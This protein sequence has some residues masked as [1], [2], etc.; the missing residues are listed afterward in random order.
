[1]I[2]EGK[3]KK[4]LLFCF[5][6]MDGSGKS[7]ISK[8]LSEELQ[9]KRYNVSYT[10]WLEPENSWMRKILRKTG[11]SISSDNTGNGKALTKSGS[12]ILTNRISRTI[13][14][15]IVIL[16][17]L[18]FGIIKAGYFDISKKHKILIFDRY[19]FDVVYSL[20][21]EFNFSEKA[22]NKILRLFGLI[23]PTPD[24][25]IFID[26][27]P[28]IAYARKKEELKT[29]KNAKIIWDNFNDI[30]NIVTRFASC[31]TT[32]IDNSNDISETKLEVI[33][34][35]LGIIQ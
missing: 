13:Y 3:L 22:R 27:T 5:M 9:N 26:V 31:R 28:E 32:T 8:Y 35:V 16:D 4:R 19:Y 1:M 10:W 25:M 30:R 7:T 20:S 29:V 17:Y 12:N 33:R 23:L 15:T 21:K 14:V 34:N 24:L 18:R 2:M 11:L 6:G